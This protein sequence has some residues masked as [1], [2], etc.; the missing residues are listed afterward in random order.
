MTRKF[1]CR[2]D[3]LN[4]RFQINRNYFPPRNQAAWCSTFSNPSGGMTT[5]T[6]SHS[7]RLSHFGQREKQSP[8][9]KVFS[10]VQHSDA[11]SPNSTASSPVLIYVLPFNGCISAIKVS[12]PEPGTA[13]PHVLRTVR[14]VCPDKYRSLKKRGH[15]LEETYTRDRFCQ[16][17]MKV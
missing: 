4:Y 13:F 11:Y 2:R 8:L 17:V 3:G 10:T 1:A 6:F 15:R 14:R 16:V 9:L 12:N 7:H 5:S